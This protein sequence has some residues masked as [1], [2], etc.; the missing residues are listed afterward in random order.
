M[1][2]QVITV[3]DIIKRFLVGWVVCGFILVVVSCIKYKE[4]I[5]AAFVDNM[6]TWINIA[7][8]V[9]IMIFGF[10]LLFKSVTC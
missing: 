4:F 9:L 3:G 6:W 7:M 2:Y 1:D 8:P 5:I 10:K